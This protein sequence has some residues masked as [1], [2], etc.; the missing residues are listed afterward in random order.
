MKMVFNN[1]KVWCKNL[2]KILIK[3]LFKKKIRL[4]TNFSLSEGVIVLFSANNN[5]LYMIICL[6]C[7]TFP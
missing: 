3:P 2:F 4:H 6:L 1:V 5:K 7:L